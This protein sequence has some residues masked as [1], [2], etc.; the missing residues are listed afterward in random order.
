[1]TSGRLCGS[2]WKSN[3]VAALAASG[4][5]VWKIEAMIV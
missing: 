5:L 1:M 2:L 4:V 3:I